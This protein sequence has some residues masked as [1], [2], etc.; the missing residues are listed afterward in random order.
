MT[1]LKSGMYDFVG[2]DLHHERHLEALKNIAEKYPVRDML[3]TSP[4]LN[5]TL[6]DHLDSNKSQG[7]AG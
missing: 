4:I 2:T 5:Q 6:L 3:K 1:L 7:I